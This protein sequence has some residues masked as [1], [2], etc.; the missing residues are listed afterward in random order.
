MGVVTLAT[1]ISMGLSEEVIFELKR[2]ITRSLGFFRCN[3]SYWGVQTG[4]GVWAWDMNY[5]RPG[6]LLDLILRYPGD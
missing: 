1:A 6:L 2:T 3:S 5:K 4:G